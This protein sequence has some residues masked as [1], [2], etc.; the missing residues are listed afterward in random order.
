MISNFEDFV[1]ERKGTPTGEEYTVIGYDRNHEVKLEKTFQHY[2][3]DVPDKALK[4]ATDFFNKASKSGKYHKLYLK[5][6]ADNVL[7]R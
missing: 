1:N 6:E 5:D 2:N 3:T 4:T 7:R